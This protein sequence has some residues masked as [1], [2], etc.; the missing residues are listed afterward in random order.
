M[1]IP[2]FRSGQSAQRADQALKQS[3]AV[4]DRAQHCAVLWFAEVL[5][6]RLFTE[7]GYGSMY[8][9]AAEELGFSATKTGD[10]KRLAEKLETLPGVAAKVKTGELGYTKAREIVKVADPAN[11]DE[12]LAVAA[13]QTRRELEA[14]VKHAKKVAA[15]KRKTNPAQ[16]ELVPRNFPASPPAVA[17][18]HVGFDLTPVQLARYETLMARIGPQENKAD[19]LLEMMEALLAGNENAPRGVAAPHYQIHVHEC[20]ACAKSSVQTVQGEKEL[21]RTEAEAV[22]C[23]ANI[24]RP[25]RRNHSTIPPRI[26]REVLA[27]DRHRCRRKGCNHSRFLEVH[28]LVPRSQGG[29]HDPENLVTLCSSCH[30]LWHQIGG[31]LKGLLEPSCDRLTGKANLTPQPVRAVTCS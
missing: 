10:F 5:Q 16:T 15:Q 31:D 12:W 17:T 24:H 30:Q 14:T 20:P 1:N 7:L 18:T 26:R 21:T 6:R 25:G 9:Y 3:V 11:E 28:H 19:L 22:R 27:R 13:K 23:D 29:T 8:Q 2:E 4:M